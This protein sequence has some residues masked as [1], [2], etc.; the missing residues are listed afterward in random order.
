MISHLVFLRS[1]KRLK[2]DVRSG[3]DIRKKL[4]L[5]FSGKV[6]EPFS[7]DELNEIYLEGEFRFLNKIPPGFRDAGKGSDSTDFNYLGVDYKRKFGDLIIWKQLIKE[8]SKDEV[9]NVIFVTDDKK[10]DW[11]Y[12]V[13][14]KIIG[15]QERLQTEFYTHTGV[16]NFKMYDTGDFLR[17]AIEYLGTKVDDKSLDDVKQVSEPFSVGLSRIG[18]S[19]NIDDHESEDNSFVDYEMD[20]ESADELESDDDLELEDEHYLKDDEIINKY[21]N[22]PPSH[23]ESDN[24]IINNI[25]HSGGL[26]GYK[27]QEEAIRRGLSS[28]M[29]HEETMRLAASG[30]LASYKAQEEA[31]RRS[32]SSRRKHE[33]AMRLAASGGLASYKA[34]E[35]A[36]RRSLS[37]RRKHEEA[38]RLAASGGLA[39]YKAQEEAIRRS[40]SSRMKHEEAMRLAASGGLASYKAQEEAIRRSLSS[41]RKHEEAMRLAASGGLADYKAQEEAIRQIVDGDESLRNEN[42]GHVDNHSDSQ[43]EVHKDFDKKKGDINS[44]DEAE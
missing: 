18:E 13:G 20:Y 19:E 38:M 28:R 6:G 26:A 36:I 21:I 39:S 22:Q 15:P 43:Q 9:L 4:D 7:Q 41:R 16:D 34:Q 29:K 2:P 32:L 8:S 10:N 3:D 30:G 27:A 31:I 24:K 23:Y 12:G 40:L 35:E 25:L 14:D 42:L 5:I 17:D 11:W 37:S 1:K 33:E 44:D